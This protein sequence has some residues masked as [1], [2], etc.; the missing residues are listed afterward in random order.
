MVQ[1]GP[2]HCES[3]LAS[4]IHPY[5]TRKLTEKEEETGWYE[6]HTPVS[7]HANTVMGALVDHKT[8][9]KAYRLG[10]LDSKPTLG[11]PG[12]DILPF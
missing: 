2:Y 9:K 3:C 7:E 5:D 10:L 4:E 11:E 12:N 1:C 6:P 8:A